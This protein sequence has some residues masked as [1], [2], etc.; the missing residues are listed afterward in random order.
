M[1]ELKITITAPD[2]TAAINNL[3]ASLAGS[4]TNSASAPKETEHVVSAPTAQPTPPTVPVNPN[5]GPVT[6]Q[7]APP[8]PA[9]A[10]PTAAPQYTLEMISTAGAALLDAGRVNELVALFAEFGVD[11]LTA[12]SPDKYGAVATKLRALGAAI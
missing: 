12:L 5:S 2:L 10:I 7:A 9:P 8:A 3:A 1:L 6:P 4:R 11:N